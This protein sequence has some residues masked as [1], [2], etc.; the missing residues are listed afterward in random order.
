MV[1]RGYRKEYDIY[2]ANDLNTLPQAYFTSKCRF[3]R[4]K[5]LFMILMKS[6]RAALAMT[7]RGMAK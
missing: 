2:H 4:K 7:A 3:K 5:S 6:K 1:A